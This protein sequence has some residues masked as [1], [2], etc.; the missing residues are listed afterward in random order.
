MTIPPS[1][2]KI[3]K[4]IVNGQ[5]QLQ[6]EFLALKLLLTRFA[7]TIKN[8]PSPATLERCAAGF[9]N[10]LERNVHLPAAKRDI[11]KILN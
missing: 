3:W 10:L 2:S 8:G 9:H 4:E 5:V 11:V 6:F 1:S 7:A